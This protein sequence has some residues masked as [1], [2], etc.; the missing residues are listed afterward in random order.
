MLI[1][2]SG[3]CFDG[4]G[5]SAV[6]ISGIRNASGEEELIGPEPVLRVGSGIAELT[7]VASG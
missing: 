4:I 1:T 7:L 5:A 6:I 2:T 3:T